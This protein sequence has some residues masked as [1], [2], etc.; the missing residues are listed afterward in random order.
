VP[1]RFGEFLLDPAARLLRRGE[2]FVHLTPKALELLELLV[3]RRPAAVSKTEIHDRLWPKT[4]VSDA[5]LPVL[6]HEI[7]EALGDDPHA[8]RWLRTVSRTGYA[9]CGRA[10]A[11][12]EWSVDDEPEP[13]CW[14]RWGQREFPLFAGE[15]LVGRTHEAAVF[16]DHASVSR[17]HALVHVT[18]AGATIEDCGSRNGCFRGSTR[19]DGATRLEDGDEVILGEAVV[20]FRT[21]PDRADASGVSTSPIARPTPDDEPSSS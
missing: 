14:M 11:E 16:V 9:F 13:R 21:R 17:R 5:N 8:P 6:V 15:N 20:V 12:R 2:A 19:L 18:A 7:R 4:F 1:V 3:E 10:W